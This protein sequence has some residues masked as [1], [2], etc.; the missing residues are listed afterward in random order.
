MI[1]PFIMV[2]TKRFPGR[3]SPDALQLLGKQLVEVRTTMARVADTV[4]EVQTAQEKVADVLSGVQAAQTDARV[5]DIVQGFTREEPGHCVLELRFKLT[6][7]NVRDRAIFTVNLESHSN[8]HLLDLGIAGAAT[9][10]AGAT[11]TQGGKTA[12]LAYDPMGAQLVPLIVYLDKC[13]TLKVK[14]SYFDR[15]MAVRYKAQR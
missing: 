14:G 10:Y 2:A 11:I 13:D 8:S 9:N 4:S 6:N 15:E 3:S 7:K 5:T 12:E 1:G